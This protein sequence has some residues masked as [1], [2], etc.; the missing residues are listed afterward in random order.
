VAPSRDDPPPRMERSAASV[1]GQG[2]QSGSGSSI[3]RLPHGRE[4]HPFFTA[5]DGASARSMRTTLRKRE[6]CWSRTSGSAVVVESPVAHELDGVL[7]FARPTRPRVRA[8]E[9]RRHGVGHGVGQ[10]HQSRQRQFLPQVPH[11]RERH[12]VLHGEWRWRPGAMEEQRYGAGTVLA[13]TSVLASARLGPSSLTDVNG[14]LFF[15]ANDEP[16]Q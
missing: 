12:V 15:R 5:S 3:S 10:G 9:E 16:A 1:H 6:R 4:R 7:Y 14:K 2:H 8:V 11:G 13:R